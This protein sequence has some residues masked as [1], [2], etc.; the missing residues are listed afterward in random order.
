MHGAIT[1]LPQCAIMTWCSIKAQ[2]QLYLLVYQVKVK[3]KVKGKVVSV[4]S[5]TEHHAMKAFGG[6]EV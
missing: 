4:L 3:V 1:P 6:V 5:L 2:G